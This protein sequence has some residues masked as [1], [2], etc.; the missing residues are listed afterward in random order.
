MTL[1]RTLIASNVQLSTM[2]WGAPGIGKS[3]IV[4]QVADAC[5]CSRLPAASGR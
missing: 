2:I 1:V 4:A 5:G 3:S